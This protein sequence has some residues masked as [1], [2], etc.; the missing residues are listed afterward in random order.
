MKADL[1]VDIYLRKSRADEELERTL[2]QGETLSRH[3]N[4]L[5]RFAKENNFIIVNIH[6]EL[7]SGEE[8]FFRPAM[9]ETLKDVETRLVN[10]VLVMDIQRLGRG[11]MEEQGLILKTFKKA[12]AVIIT[13]QKIYDLNNEFDE[14][15][16]EF[17]TFMARKE[18]KM[19]TRRLQGGRIRSI[20]EG[21]YIGTY[22]PFGYEIYNPDKRTRTLLPHP[23]NANV[24]Q[25]IFKM[26]VENNM[27]CGTIADHLNNIGLKSVTGKKWERSAISFILKNEIYIGKVVWKKKAIKKSKVNGKKRDVYTR[28]RSDWIVCNGKHEPIVDESLFF[29]AQKIINNKYHV[30]Y[31]L[32]GTTNPLAGLVICSVCKEKMQRRPY[33]SS[34]AHLI[35][36]NKCGNKSNRI[37]SVEKAVIKDM[38]DYINAEWDVD[39]SAI[40][41]SNEIISILESNLQDLNAELKNVSEQRNKAFDLLEQ[42]VYDISVF[43]ERSNLLSERLDN[44]TSSIAKC[45]DEL[46]NIK[47]LSESKKVLNNKIRK[48]LDIYD[49]LEDAADRNLMLKDIIDTIEYK[50]GQSFKVDEFDIYITYKVYNTYNM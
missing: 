16:S 8:L 21:N 1:K 2:G 33:G 13:P 31:Q 46:H 35:C 3:R 49:T 50:K 18:Y 4:A 14:E 41:D 23:N 42:G 28:D 45:Q 25:M 37:D 38:E 27:G 47:S 43:T 26:Y 11:D 17:E 6:E 9:L 5:L 19:I 30:P 36:K 22:A 44:I 39:E 7:V 12:N 24:V 29:E 10:G 48:I 34:P 40:S 15:Y 32:N 20:E